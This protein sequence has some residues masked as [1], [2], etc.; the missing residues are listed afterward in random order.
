MIS[1][2]GVSISTRLQTRFAMA[3]SMPASGV[4]GRLLGDMNGA[5]G[6]QRQ[7]GTQLLLSGLGPDGHRDD[8]R[9]DTF[10]LQPHRLFHGDLTERVHGHLDVGQVDVGVI[11][12]DADLDVVV[13]DAFDRDEYFIASP[14][15]AF[16]MRN[17]VSHYLKSKIMPSEAS[18]NNLPARPK[19]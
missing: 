15:P 14:L 17:T 6:T 8:F 16:A 11:R 9:G 4:L 13:N 2:R 1:R 3:I 5:I 12:L 10:L 19:V 18:S 7:R